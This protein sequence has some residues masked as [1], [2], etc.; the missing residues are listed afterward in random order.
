M[1]G[2]LIAEVTRPLIAEMKLLRE[3][4]DSKYSKLEDAIASQHQEVTDE[5]HKLEET[6]TN[7]KNEAN[8]ELLSKINTN[9]KSIERILERNKSLEKENLA[10]QDKLDQIEME[11]LGNNVIITAIPEQPWESYEHTKQ[12]VINTVA[13]SLGTTNDPD[14]LEEAKKAKISCCTRL[15]KQHPNYDH[16]ISVTFQRKVGREKLMKGK[17]NLPVGVYVNEEF[18]LHIKHARDR[19]QP[20]M[21]YIKTNLK[22]KDKCRIQGDKLIVD[23]IKYSMVN[24]GDL[25]AEIAAYRVAKKSDDTHLVFHGELSPYSNFHPG[26]FTIDGME[27]AT[28]EHYIQYQK[29]LFFG[30]SLN[31]NQVLKSETAL[32]AK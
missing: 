2:P 5:I 24:I 32:E 21:R 30:D 23:G 13:A 4:V 3:S 17:K 25:P 22:Y 16:P 6:V 15:G 1:I 31:A 8:E 27:F 28:V 19:L 26:R 20:V 9:Q 12:Q 14:A 7:Q 10:L 11:Q 18:L 29:S